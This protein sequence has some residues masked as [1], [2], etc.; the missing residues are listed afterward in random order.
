MAFPQGVE[1]LG[2]AGGH[3]ETLRSL[4]PP[5]AI[6]PWMLL[7]VEVCDKLIFCWFCISDFPSGFESRDKS[8]TC[9]VI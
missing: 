3:G 4:W 9:F 6:H 7:M 1:G 5:L 8:K 2:M